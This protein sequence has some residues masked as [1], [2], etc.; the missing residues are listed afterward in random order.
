MTMTKTTSASASVTNPDVAAGV[1]QYLTPIVIDMTA[2]AVNGKQAHWHVRGTGFIGIHELLDVVV[3]HA[4]DWADLPA[5]R[6]IALG[7]PVDARL[8]TVAKETTAAPLSAGFQQAETTISEIVA[9]MDAAL[10]KINVAIAE[11]GE[12][13]PGSQDIAIQIEVGLT[14]DRWLLGAYISA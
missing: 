4:R 8:G 2:L 11:L 6:V 3:A 1:A 12:I 10:A 5:E 14:K 7:L 9:Q 13:D